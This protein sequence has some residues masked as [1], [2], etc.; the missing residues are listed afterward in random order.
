MK[1]AILALCATGAVALASPANAAISVDGTTL[2]P[3]QSTTLTFDGATGTGTP[4]AG[5][6]STLGLT[7]TGETATSYTFSYTLSMIDATAADLSGFGFMSAPEIQSFSR[8]GDL[9]VTLNTLFPDNGGQSVDFCAYSG[10]NC[11]AGS[12]HA[13]SFSGTF[14]L[15]Y[16]AGA[17]DVA[18]TDFVTRYTG[19]TAANG[20][21]GIGHVTGAVPEPATWAM[22]LLG[23]GAIGVSMRRRKPV[24][25]Q[26]A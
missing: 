13:D 22:M 12:G 3:G 15:N 16:A 10:A 2:S 5:L 1:K 4:V 23:F 9:N 20:V 11:T 26:V 8:S 18:L 19:I 17:G 7:L 25:A 21:S 6:G 24:L 14:T